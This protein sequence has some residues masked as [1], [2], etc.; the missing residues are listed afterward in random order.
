MVYIVSQQLIRTLFVAHVVS[1]HQMKVMNQK[2]AKR[3]YQQKNFS[4]RKLTNQR[5]GKQLKHF[6][7]E[8][9]R[10]MTLWIITPMV[11]TLSVVSSHTTFEKKTFKTECN[12]PFVHIFQISTL[13]VL[14]SFL[15][16]AKNNLRIVH[17]S[18]RAEERDW[19]K[20]SHCKD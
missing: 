2:P 14:F 7:Q 3:K 19:K 17:N 11:L 20:H 9:P 15:L 16:H 10:L 5:I 4:R 6:P 1:K 12:S 8:S 13:W 18:N